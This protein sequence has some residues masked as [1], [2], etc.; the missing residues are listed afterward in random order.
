VRADRALD[1]DLAGAD[2]SRLAVSGGLALRISVSWP[3]ARPTPT[4]SPERRRKARRS[5]VGNALARPRRRLWTKGEEEE[6]EEE[7]EEALSSAAPVAFR[8]NNMVVFVLR[9]KWSCSSA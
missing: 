7:R 3:A 9:P 6:E 5:M 4:P 2:R 8:V 1:L